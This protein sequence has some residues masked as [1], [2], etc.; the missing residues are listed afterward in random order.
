MEQYL[1]CPE[2]FV[3][4]NI[5]LLYSVHGHY[6]IL[7]HI[8][9]FTWENM[10]NLN[11]TRVIWGMFNNQNS[12][13]WSLVVTCV[14]KLLLTSIC[15]EYVIVNFCAEH[16]KHYNGHRYVVADC[17]ALWSLRAKVIDFQWLFRSFSRKRKFCWNTGMHCNDCVHVKNYS[18]CKSIHDHIIAA[19]STCCEYHGSN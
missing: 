6:Y 2:A 5:L 14:I 7:Q 4:N 12:A 10:N 1:C 13:N 17:G 16:G 15:A 3:H 18:F 8:S 11:T 9:S 19:A